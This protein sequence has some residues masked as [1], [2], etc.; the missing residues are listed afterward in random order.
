M[1]IK[2]EAN[3]I[4]TSPKHKC[5]HLIEKQSKTFNC[6]SVFARRLHNIIQILYWNSGWMK[7]WDYKF[8]HM[9]TCVFRQV[10][11]LCRKKNCQQQLNFKNKLSKQ[12]QQGN[13]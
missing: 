13:D 9:K 4:L 2:N 8:G 6:L 11:F 5:H 7:K 3:K 10:A 1:T 12:R